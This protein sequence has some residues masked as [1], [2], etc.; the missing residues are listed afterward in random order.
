[1]IHWLDSGDIF[2]AKTEYIVNAVNCLGFMGAGLALA[3]K[4]KCTKE[5]FTSYQKACRNKT[6]IPGTMRYFFDTQLNKWVVDFPTMTS[7]PNNFKGSLSTIVSGLYQ[8]ADDI[9]SKKIKSIAIPALGCGIGRL[10]WE[11]VKT[12]MELILN[13][14]TNCEI[15]IYKPR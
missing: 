14:D 11:N 1:M 12:A 13:K 8:L 9:V 2:E 4:K 15:Y 10:K 7:D 3:F 5:Y 6:F